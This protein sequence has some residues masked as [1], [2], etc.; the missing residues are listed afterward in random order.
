[1]FNGNDKLKEIRGINKFITN[2]IENIK[3]RN[4]HII[5]KT[6]PIVNTTNL[7]SHILKCIKEFNNYNF[8][9]NY[10]NDEGYQIFNL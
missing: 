7:Q 6:I 5:N 4:F 2:K 1:M 9:K 8:L 3:L 10:Y